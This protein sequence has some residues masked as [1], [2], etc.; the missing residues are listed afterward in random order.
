MG[1]K[2]LEVRA[3]TLLHIA[4]RRCM[5]QDQLWAFCD[6]LDIPMAPIVVDS[7]DFTEDWNPEDLRE[8]AAIKYTNGK[9]GEGVVI[10]AQDSSWSFKVINLLYKD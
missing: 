8:L 1:L 10:R 6:T 3:F 4:S 5:S 9:H 7:Y 2:E